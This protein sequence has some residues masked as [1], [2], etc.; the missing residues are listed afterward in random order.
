MRQLLTESLVL[1]ALGGAIGLAV[2]ALGVRAL[3]ALSPAGLPRADAIGL[4]GTVFLIGAG[5]TTL[6]GLAVGMAPALNAAR[7]DPQ[8]ELQRG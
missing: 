4:D 7:A 6:V 1:A 2:A 3:V 5:I 8:A